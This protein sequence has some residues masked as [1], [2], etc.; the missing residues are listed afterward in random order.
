MNLV[1][2]LSHTGINAA[3]MARRA[4]MTRGGISRLLKG[5]RAPSVETAARIHQATDGMVTFADWMRKK[6]RKK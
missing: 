6:R 3:E 2:Y 4:K 5:T 1:Q